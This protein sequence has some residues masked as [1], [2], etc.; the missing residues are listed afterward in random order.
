MTYKKNILAIDTANEQI[1]VAF[2][3]KE[4]TLPAHRASNTML[5]PT[6]QK[7]GINP[8]E[9]NAVAVGRGPGSFTGVRIALATAKGIASALGV[10]LIG[11]STLDA[12]A[13][14]MW[15]N[16]VRGKTYVVADAMRKEIYPALYDITDDG[17]KRLTPDRVEKA[18]KVIEECG[19][20]LVAG[21]ALTKYK[22]K[23]QAPEK[24]W[25]PT[26]K[27]LLLAIN[28]KP[29]DPGTVLPVYTRLS[30]A[31]EG[32]R[33]KLKDKNLVSG[34][35]GN[36]FAPLNASNLDKV[37]ELEN[38]LM[39]DD[40]WTK[41]KFNLDNIWWQA[42]KDNKLMAYAGGILAGDTFEILK[43]AVDT[44]Y[45]NQGI[46][47]KLMSKLANDARDLGAKTF[48]L[49]V[50]ES[51]PAIKFYEKLGLKQ[52]SRRK[53]YY[54]DEDAI[55][56]QGPLPII[57]KDVAGMDLKTETANNKV[58]YPVILS[59]ESSCDETAAAITFNGKVISNVVASQVDFHKRFGG[60]VP[61]IASRKHI[62]A[63]CGVVDTCLEQANIKWTDINAVA[64]T[65]APGLVGAL[66][67]GMAYA[68]GV[69]WALDV[70]FIGVNHLEGHLYANKL[71]GKEIKLPAVA[72]IISGGNT[73][74]VE[75]KDWGDYKTLG[76]TIDD[77]VGEAFD[78]VAKALNLGYPGGPIISKLAKTGDPKAI[79]FPRAMLHSGDLKFSLSGLKTAVITY[80][81][82]NPKA[83][84]NDICASFQQAVID[85]Q[86]SKAKTAIEQTGA[87]SFMFGGGVA[88][89]PE[90]RA[91]YENLG[92]DII[93][94]P[95]E[96]CGDNAAMIGLVA[97]ERY[98]QQKFFDLSADVSAHASLD[99][100][101]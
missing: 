54:S 10:K 92:V 33:V 68:K 18:D 76:T 67:V 1:T 77:A 85:V 81:K 86:V 55:I 93:M 46:A 98:K 69:A 49:E 56:M 20:T 88:A 62:E 74:L 9:V 91:A 15:N 31:E 47:T 82:E 90:L 100:K 22:F 11:V 51:N 44:K 5:L 30:D 2:N 32:E 7:L 80:I 24:L 8:K 64:S 65:Y 84:I 13:W 23:N 83:N 61:E 29:Q 71:S 42:T 58:E 38:E 89:N 12:V 87:K 66:V 17:P 99:I 57:N 75:V 94:A 4:A 26:A 45:Q 41:E 59:I 16:N 21:D 70:P 14:N 48:T 36:T 79:N 52:I 35:Q 78:K 63:I 19:D 28:S 34:V 97:N 6:L 53:N 95:L 40:A 50:R 27:S 60:V 3:D 25:N 72:S 43:I 73:M 101:Y 96:Y 37:V 39:K